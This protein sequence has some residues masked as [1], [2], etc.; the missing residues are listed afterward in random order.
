MNIKEIVHTIKIIKNDGDIIEFKEVRVPT[1]NGSKPTT[2][3]IEDQIFEKYN[4]DFCETPDD[5]I[6]DF[7][8]LE[9]LWALKKA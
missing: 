7:R 2:K 8:N 9:D 5:I 4:I 1:E 6:Q 3:T